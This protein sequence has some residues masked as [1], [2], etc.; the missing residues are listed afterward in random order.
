MIT[1]YFKPGQ[2]I[3]LFDS[4]VDRSCVGV[5]VFDPAQLKPNQGSNFIEP[6]GMV[7]LILSIVGF[8]YFFLPVAKAE[9]YT[10]TH[11]NTNIVISPPSPVITSQTDS[12]ATSDEFELYIPKIGL[13]SKVIPNVDPNSA[14]DYK[15]V[16]SETGIAHAKGSYLPDQKKGP[17]YLFAHSTDGFWDINAFNAK[18]YALR[19]LSSGDEIDIAYHGQKYKYQVEG[20]QVIEADD[21]SFVQKSTADLLLQTCWPP[22][23]DWQRLIVSAKLI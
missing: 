13:K 7:C 5:L 3:T 17:V 11:K 20:Q 2:M 12:A 19:Q 21:L 18:F 1:R 14:E 4:R 9:L 23:T 16:L 8:S 15:K 22:G 10:R 6:L